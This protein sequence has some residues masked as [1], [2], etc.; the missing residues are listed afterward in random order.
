MVPNAPLFIPNWQIYHELNL[1]AAFEFIYRQSSVLFISTW[2]TPS[3]SLL[4]GNPFQIPERFFIHLRTFVLFSFYHIFFVFISM[5]S[6]LSPKGNS[7][8][9][10]INSIFLRIHNFLL[11]SEKCG[12]YKRF[13]LLLCD[14][15]VIKRL[16]FISPLKNVKWTYSTMLLKSAIFVRS[17]A[18]LEVHDSRSRELFR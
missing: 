15:K 14:V 2:T 13:K 9:L 12:L 6:P 17:F 8:L 16:R 10:P 5:P 3:F 7:Q 18:R 1:L 4:F 11:N